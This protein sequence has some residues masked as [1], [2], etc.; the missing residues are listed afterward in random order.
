MAQ[1][2]ATIKHRV[3][4]TADERD[5]FER[6]VRRGAAGSSVAQV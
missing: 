3:K 5:E 2:R 4:L 1:G 6:L